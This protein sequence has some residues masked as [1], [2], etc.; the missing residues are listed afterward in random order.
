MMVLQTAQLLMETG[1]QAT[2]EAEEE[3]GA[4][5]TTEAVVE[6]TPQ[7]TQQKQIALQWRLGRA[8]IHCQQTVEVAGTRIGMGDA[9]CF[10]ALAVTIADA[11]GR[12]CLMRLPKK[13]VW[14]VVHDGSAQA[15]MFSGHS[16]SR[17]GS[18]RPRLQDSL[19]ASGAAGGYASS[20]RPS[21]A[22]SPHLCTF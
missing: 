4:A 8:L 1:P 16:E 13:C 5:T 21:H 11:Y 7:A 14:Q 3:E 9:F 15:S 17:K 2:E 19:S 6:T 18:S 10:T 22:M 20:L 12:W